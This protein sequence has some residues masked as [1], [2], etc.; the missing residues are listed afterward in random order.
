VIDLDD[1]RSVFAKCAHEEPVIGFLRTEHAFYEAV[2]ADFM[3]E[4][5]LF[6]E[7]DP[8]VLVLEDLSTGQ[9]PPPWP[10]GSVEKV[11]AMLE[12]VHATPPPEHVPRLEDEREGLT[13]CWGTVAEDPQP[14][15]S[16]GVCSRE[17]LAGALPAFDEASQSAPI[18]GEELLHLDVRS[19]NVCLLGERTVLV[20]WN[21]ACVGNGLVD[22]AAWASSLRL[23]GGPRPDE[24]I[25]DCPPGLAAMLAGFFGSRAGLP[26]PPTAPF[27]REIQLTQLRVALPWAAG[28]LGLAPPA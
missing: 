16:L 15:L 26:P 21:W 4:L 7:E 20:D 25:P 11:L 8:P 2:Q 22:I 28:L 5:I 19:D 10:Q 24:L 1:G 14:F 3:P 27:V 6:L 23:E 18:A 9:W 13:D 12:R 17:W